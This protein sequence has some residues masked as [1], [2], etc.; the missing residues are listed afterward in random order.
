MLYN[1]FNEAYTTI[2]NN[3]KV[4]NISITIAEP[5]H[6]IITCPQRKLDYKQLLG[7][8]FYH[9]QGKSDLE[10]LLYYNKSYKAF[11]DD[12]ETI[13]G[14]LG[15]RIFSYEGLFDI[16]NNKETNEIEC[17][18][19][20]IDQFQDC[21]TNF[22]NF[23]NIQCYNPILDKNTLNSCNVSNLIFTKNHNQ[24]DLTVNVIYLDFYYRFPYLSFFVSNLL[25]IMASRLQLDI[26]KIY[27]NINTL[28]NYKQVKLNSI[29]FVNSNDCIYYDA[30]MFT[31]MFDIEL[32]SRIQ[33]NLINKKEIKEILYSINNQY[34]QS[35]VAS[36]LKFNT[37]LD[38]FDKFILDEH[39]VMFSGNN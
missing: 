21:F 30:D 6:N 37:G 23:Y 24:L 28:I 4:H 33:G 10:S 20:I 29:D 26:G 27:I 3:N 7:L 38:T 1:T 32:M 16:Y 39:K 14:M 2:L 22:K 9:L 8:L 36:L 17:E 15:N 18:H 5:K 12:G 25:F 31:R 19:I 34:W 35:L 11:S 13:N